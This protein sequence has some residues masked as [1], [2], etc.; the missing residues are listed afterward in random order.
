MINSK[1]LGFGIKQRT[2]S[3]NMYRSR[4]S[5]CSPQTGSGFGAS[6]GVRRCARPPVSGGISCIWGRCN[7]VRRGT[8]SL[9]RVRMPRPAAG[10]RLNAAR[11]R[12]CRRG[13]G[14]GG[15]RARLAHP[16]GSI[17]LVLSTDYRLEQGVP[18]P[19]ASPA[20][21][22]RALLPKPVR[23]LGRSQ[24]HARAAQA[25]RRGRRRIAAA[26][27]AAV[28]SWPPATCALARPPLREPHRLAP[29]RRLV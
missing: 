13:R 7:S 18:S 1:K 22:L 23:L 19:C 27:S 8:P 11:R 3:Q 2:P 21:P 5:R 4:G 29:A 6:P 25:R 12:S 20:C 16:R 14:G 10:E 17:I 26:G 24:T 9:A 28:R 15:A